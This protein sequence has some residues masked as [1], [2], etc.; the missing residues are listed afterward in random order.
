M[1]KFF[2]NAETCQYE[3]V[4][5]SAGKVIRRGLVFFGFS[6]L[7]GVGVSFLYYG[8]YVRFKEASSL[9][10]ENEA[11]RFYYEKLEGEM[12]RVQSSLM[13][14][15]ERDD[16]IYRVVFEVD[17]V[18]GTVRQAGV[19]GTRRYK[20]LLNKNLVS[21]DM[22]LRALRRAEN[23]KHQISIQQSSYEELLQLG[24][25]KNKRLA[26]V[27]STQPVSN[28]TLKRL[29][30][31]FGNRIDPIYKVRKFHPGV[32]FAAPQGTPV[33]ATGNAKVVKVAYAPRGYGRYLVLDHGYHYQTLYAHLR[34]TTVRQHQVVKR[35][36]LIGY[37]GKHRQV[38]GPSSALRS[39]L[40]K[41]KNRPRQVLLRR[42]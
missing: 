41:K 36:E 19:G 42:G 28:K 29:S 20:D 4:R 33:Y 37:V 23:L 1:K 12:E 9:E 24:L 30:S 8:Y 35:G 15:R 13:N 11:L 6:M 5:L 22:V 27:P 17:P 38:H 2:Y 39:A 26:S 31:G 7:M 18:P 25:S 16:D 10:L 21:E 32:D 34:R 3:P 14:L 40:Q